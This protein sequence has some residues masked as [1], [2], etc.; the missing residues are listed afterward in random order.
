M[1]ELL[2][3]AVIGDTASVSGFSALG[4]SVFHETEAEKVTKLINRLAS[5][6]FGVIYITE[7]VAVLV[8]DTIKKYR[9]HKLPSIVLIP[10][11]EGNT[12]EGMRGVHETV[13]KAVGSD[14]LN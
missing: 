12:G 1:S 14:I 4:L 5:S 2:K 13:E 9:S 11:I 3:T 6:G 10:A 7:P 8:S